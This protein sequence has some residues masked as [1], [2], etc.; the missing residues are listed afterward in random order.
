[1]N[2]IFRC[3][4][5][6]KI[7][8]GHLNRCRSL[9]YYLNKKG[10]DCLMV[11]PSKKFI[12]SKDLKIFKKWIPKNRW[13]NS[14]ED[15]LNLIKIAKK[16][17]ESFIILDDYRVDANYQLNIK[18]A[19]LKC[20]QFY[21]L[22]HSQNIIGD[23]IHCSVPGISI[24][25]LKNKILN[26]KAKFLLGPKYALLRPEFSK[27]KRKKIKSINR[28][29]LIFGGGNDLGA[30]QYLLS[31]LLPLADKNIQFT[32]VSSLLNKSN[33]KLKKL[34]ETKYKLRVNLQIN[35]KKIS[36][37]ML[38]QDLAITAGGTT[39][40]ELDV[41]GVPMI[42]IS[43]AV[44]QI[45][46]SKAWS[47][48]GRAKYLGNLRFIKKE[49]LKSVFKS[50]LKKKQKIFQKKVLTSGDGAN[51]VAEFLINYK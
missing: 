22:E 31:T 19:G 34:V 42:I 45:K 36:K 51:K 23:I 12:N 39:T 43:T 46:Q 40:Y 14:S 24:K 18:K 26:K 30:N 48:Y 21:N 11:G 44:N 16:N 9:A 32:I 25:K 8:L 15:S 17:R 7:G 27:L 5:G 2:F 47:S 29:I 4:A 10:Q 50:F 41:C 6:S 1:M 38:D 3:N 28:V 37:L 35:P 33:F 13:K 20:L 49:S